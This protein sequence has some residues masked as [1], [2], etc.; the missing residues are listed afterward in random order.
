MIVQFGSVAV[1]IVGGGLTRRTTGSMSCSPI[2][3][4]TIAF[5]V[6]VP[7]AVG[8][9]EITPERESID[10]PGGRPAAEKT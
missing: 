4:V 6:Y 9:P 8:V 7:V 5:T 10:K 1:E 2:E 3:S